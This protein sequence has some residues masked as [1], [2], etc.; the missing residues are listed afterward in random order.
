MNPTSGLGNK[1]IMARNIQHY[2]AL[3]GKSRKEV[4]EAIG[5]KYTTFTDWVKG[6]AYPRI[7]KI[8]LMANY[9]DIS[10]SDLVEERNMDENNIT[11]TNAERDII[12]KYRSLDDRGKQSIIDT[13]NREYSYVEVDKPL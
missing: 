7:D 11:I 1:E 10:K 4:C 8:E 2:M 9:F 5:V 3:K 12:M 13:L 6:S